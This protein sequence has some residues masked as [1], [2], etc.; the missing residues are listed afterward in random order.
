MD[1]TK[2]VNCEDGETKILT[3]N[4]NGEVNEVKIKNIITKEKDEVRGIFNTFGSW[5]SK[6]VTDFTKKFKNLGLWV[7]IFIM[8]GVCIGIYGT[9]IYVYSRINETILLGGFVYGDH[10]YTV[11]ENS[12][13]TKPV[14][15]QSLSIQ[16]SISKGKYKK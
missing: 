5:I 8:I 14:H 13:I 15:D 2:E 4:E 9:R 16:D 12:T 11:N 6:K 10:I 7:L 1:E 3:I